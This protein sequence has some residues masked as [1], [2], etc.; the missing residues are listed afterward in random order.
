MVS[1]GNMR[2]FMP[3][4]LSLSVDEFIVARPPVPVNTGKAK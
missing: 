4:P 3:M 1:D 2:L